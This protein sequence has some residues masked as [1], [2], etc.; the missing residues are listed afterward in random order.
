M[1]PLLADCNR[2]REA[3]DVSGENADSAGGCGC[4]PLAASDDIDTFANADCAAATSTGLLRAAAPPGSASPLAARTGAPSFQPR[5]WCAACQP[6]AG[7]PPHWTR[8]SRNAI[9]SLESWSV[10]RASVAFICAP[11]TVA[12]GQDRINWGRS[13]GWVIVRSY[14]PVPT[15]EHTSNY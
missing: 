12:D 4:S 15:H 10:Y 8:R 14:H 5:H 13:L 9:T 2:D 1:L 11:P 7:V 3:G 6:L